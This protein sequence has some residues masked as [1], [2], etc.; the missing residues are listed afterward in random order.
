MDGGMEATLF[1]EWS[2]DHLVSGGAM[3]GC[4]QPAAGGGRREYIWRAVVRIIFNA[5]A[6]DAA[7]KL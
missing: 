2:Y 5:G 1:T 3:V 6:R 7:R 4:G